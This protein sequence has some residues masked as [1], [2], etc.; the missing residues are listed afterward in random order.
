MPIQ[1]LSK[2]GYTF[3]FYISSKKFK[4]S[5]LSEQ[6]QAQFCHNI[7]RLLCKNFTKLLSNV[8]LNKPVLIKA[9]ATIS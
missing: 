6:P 7:S 5:T 4:F 2:V 1:F 9:L 3:S 8:D